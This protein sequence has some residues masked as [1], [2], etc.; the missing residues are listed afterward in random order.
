MNIVYGTDLIPDDNSSQ[1][2]STVFKIDIGPPMC[3]LS[4]KADPRDIWGQNYLLRS[5]TFI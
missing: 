4:F 5:K 1:N 2:L 3:H